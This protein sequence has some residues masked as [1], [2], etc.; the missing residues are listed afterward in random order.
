[1][2][3][4]PPP[5]GP[6][7]EEGR[8]HSA[9][10]VFVADVD[11]PVLDERDVHHIVR[12]LRVRSGQTVSVTDGA[13]R[14]RLCAADSVSGGGRG[15]A[16]LLHPTSAVH[17]DPPLHPPLTVAFAPTKG[18][19]PEWALAKLTEL[20]IEQIVPLITA[21]SVVRWDEDR[22]DRRRQRWVEV[23]RQAAMQCRR[24][25]LPVIAEPAD[26]ASVVTAAEGTA[27]LARLGGA[28]PSRRH[29]TILIGPEGGWSADEQGLVAPAVGLGPLVLRT[30]TAAVVAAS[31]FV[32]LRTGAV[33]ERDVTEPDHGK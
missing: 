25:R 7:D 23:A 12:V 33:V 5:S 30:E 9:A 22:R 3:A 15:S 29:R 4:G 28:P 24:V 14:W 2:V 8:W 31:L 32:A 27:V 10:H 6:G 1:M 11:H 21:R 26:V 16:A 13:G 17:L 20:G 18:E 19:R